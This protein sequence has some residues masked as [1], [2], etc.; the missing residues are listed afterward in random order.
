MSPDW[1]QG[2]DKHQRRKPRASWMKEL[3]SW[4]NW[5]GLKWL[6]WGDWTIKPTFCCSS[7]RVHPPNCWGS[8]TCDGSPDPR[9]LPREPISFL[10]PVRTGNWIIVVLGSSFQIKTNTFLGLKK[11]KIKSEGFDGSKHGWRSR[12]RA[13][14]AEGSSA[15]QVQVDLD[16]L[17]TLL[18]PPPAPCP[19]PRVPVTG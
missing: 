2:E 14:L 1:E 12:A 11:K 3:P 18:L 13:R 7:P 19:V 17:V 6:K 5:G 16:L 15:A 4:E 9:L 10:L 8:L